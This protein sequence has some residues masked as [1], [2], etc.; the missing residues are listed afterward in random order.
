MGVT[1]PSPVAI[2]DDG[3]TS[4]TSTRPGPAAFKVAGP[5][6][7]TTLARGV[8]C[9]G[10]HASGDVSRPGDLYRLPQLDVVVGNKQ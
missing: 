4:T 8:R 10:R 3:V 5:T 9:R 6:I 1:E 7:R 2:P